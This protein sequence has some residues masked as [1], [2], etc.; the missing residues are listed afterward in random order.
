MTKLLIAANV[1]IYIASAGLYASNPDAWGRLLHQLWVHPDDFHWWTLWTSAFLHADVLHIL[2]NMLFLWAFGPNLEDRL[3]KVGFLGFYLLGAA[4]A[5]GLHAGFDADP[6]IGASGAVSAVTGAYL[7]M[8][9]RTI[10]RCLLLFIFVNVPAWW[11]IGFSIFWDV[12]G[13][14]GGRYGIAYLAHFGG[15]AF[16]IAAAFG[17]L[18]TGVLKPEP[19][20]LFMMYR[21]KRRREQIRSAVEHSHQRGPIT[22]SARRRHREEPADRAAAA[23]AEVSRLHAEGDTPAAAVRYKALLADSGADRALLSRR[24]QY[25]LGAHFFSEGD[26]QTAAI[27]FQRFLKGYPDDRETAEVKLMLGLINARYLNDPIEARRL[28]EDARHH[29]REPSQRELAESILEDLG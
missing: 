11:L 9:P 6:A 13:A 25:D 7:V 27:T 4:A 19:Y 5:S 28:L 17:L 18:A 22:A 26:Y 3:G 8:F 29:L 14:G 2:F 24:P 23:R 12:V 10:I 21:Q 20:D 15:T 1:V 16:G